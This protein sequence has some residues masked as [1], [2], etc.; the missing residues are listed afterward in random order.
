MT[1][2]TIPERILMKAGVKTTQFV[3]IFVGNTD[4]TLNN[5]VSPTPALH[6]QIQ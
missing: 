1:T 3:L 2:A 5:T 6:K 4:I